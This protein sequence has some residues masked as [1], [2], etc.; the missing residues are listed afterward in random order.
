MTLPT[1]AAASPTAFVK[2]AAPYTGAASYDQA[3]HTRTG[4]G[5]TFPSG[6]APTF[7]LTTGLAQ[8]TQGAGVT[9]CASGIAG[10]ATEF[11]RSGVTDLNFTAATNGSY[12]VT[13]HWV[14]N[15]SFA[16]ALP[17]SGFTAT[18]RLQAYL[19]LIDWSALTSHCGKAP[20][21][22]LTITSG[23]GTVG[24]AYSVVELLRNSTV[25]AGTTY[26]IEA[27]LYGFVTVT[28]A[29][30]VVSGSGSAMLRMASAGTPVWGG[31]LTHVKVFA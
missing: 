31:Y 15:G 18:Y 30:G 5:G 27:Y 14:T 24:V 3:H 2:F 1:T 29:N 9:A 6:T 17:A 22:K 12:N 25:T 11:V 8:W 20:A 28:S 16:Y 7:N 4:C 13:A 26:G 23:N 21:D 10:S 19:C